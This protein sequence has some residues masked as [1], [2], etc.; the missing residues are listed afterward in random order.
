MPRSRMIL[1]SAAGLLI[2]CG[3][4][5]LTVSSSPSHPQELAS[6]LARQHAVTSPAESPYIYHHH[7]GGATPLTA[8]V[9]R[10]PASVTVHAGDT[11]GS[12]AASTLG[13]SADWPALYLANQ[14]VIGSNPDVLTAGAT[15]TVPPAS[16]VP[17]LLAQWSKQVR[18]TAPAPA[19]SVTP[20]TPPAAGG[21]LTPAQVGALW[22]EAGGPAS[23]ET[24]ME[25]IANAES[26]DNPSLNN[27]TDNG[28]TQTSWGLFQV[29]NGTHSMPVPD[30]DNPLVNAG[31]AV[32]KYRASGFAPW[33]TAPGCGV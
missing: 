33:T 15:L 27:Y 21:V 16:G 2:A 31:Q 23:A 7:T 17:G 24:A 4:W 22:L 6:V 8:E 20:V 28:G 1:L 32:A 29:S 18:T 11:L 14:K 10:P 19:S 25:C 12:L 26:G 5:L 13:T 3:G 30:I 9:T